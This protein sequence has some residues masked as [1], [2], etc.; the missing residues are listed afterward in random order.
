MVSRTDDSFY[1]TKLRMGTRRSNE[2]NVRCHCWWRLLLWQIKSSRPTSQIKFYFLKAK[3]AYNGAECLQLWLDFGGAGH[4]TALLFG[5]NAATFHFDWIVW[6]WCD[7]IFSHCRWLNQTR[8]PKAMKS[9]RNYRSMDSKWPQSQHNAQ[10]HWSIKMK[11]TK[12]VTEN[13]PVLLLLYEWM[14]QICPNGRVASVQLKLWT[15]RTIVF[16][17]NQFLWFLSSPFWFSWVDVEVAAIE[18]TNE[19]FRNTYIRYGAVCE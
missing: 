7:I 1:V 5:I 12:I 14:K 9:R 13:I 8:R 11:S 18:Q 2:L 15:S 3:I 17:C 16:H 19:L 6:F 10:W 4:R